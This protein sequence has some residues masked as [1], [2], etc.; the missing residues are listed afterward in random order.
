MP[1]ILR[2]VVIV[3]ATALA[4]PLAASA[5]EVTVRFLAP[6]TYADADLGHRLASER[7]RALV[8]GEIER[9]LQGLARSSL[10]ADQTLAIEVLDVDLAGRI[11]P[12]PRASSQDLRVVRAIDAPR[13]HLR[14]RLQQ[15]DRVLS[16]G[17]ERLSD[18]GFL[19]SSVRRLG[20]ESLRH[21]KALLDRWVAGLVSSSRP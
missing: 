19:D 13:I 10:P 1:R 18:L 21:E 14:Y 20:N 16:Q 2:P 15:G 4:L 3:V 12:F 9:H 17:E 6:E 5:G 8:L 11:E 7:G